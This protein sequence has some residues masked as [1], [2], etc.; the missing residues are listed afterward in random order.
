MYRAWF[1]VCVCYLV[2]LAACFNVS[3]RDDSEVV[4][5]LGGLP[6]TSWENGTET[7]ALVEQWLEARLRRFLALRG[8]SD[9]AKEHLS[10]RELSS[11][12]HNALPKPIITSSTS[13]SLALFTEALCPQLTVD[14]IV[15]WAAYHSGLRVNSHGANV[16]D[17]PPTA[18][19]SKAKRD[20]A[21]ALCQRLYRERVLGIKTLPERDHSETSS[22]AQHPENLASNLEEQRL[23][24]AQIA[25]AE[26][27]PH[28]FEPD[29]NPA[30]DR[31]AKHSTHDLK[32]LLKVF[33]VQW[34]KDVTHARLTEL[35]KLH[36][37]LWGG[38]V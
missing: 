1:L 13:A 21:V 38:H 37:A 24:S 18:V 29:V 4:L 3:H 35:A 28:V 22:A 5:D 33:G 12:V 9:D 27:A 31:A 30:L 16:F 2:G 26:A 17:A 34:E 23:F 14:Q 19:R 20:A 15:H 10:H 11:F 32:D 6:N 25:E 8:L 36:T 7:L